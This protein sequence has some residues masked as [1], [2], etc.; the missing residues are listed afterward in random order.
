[1]KAIILSFLL[2]SSV[3]INPVFCQPAQT[4]IENIKLKQEI[5]NLKDIIEI[6]KVI[7]D[8]TEEKNKVHTIATV[9]ENRKDNKAKLRINEL[10]REIDKCIAHL[11]K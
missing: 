10:V 7:I 5:K 2:L 1:M 4:T 9:L 3:L 8:K 11:N 6:Q